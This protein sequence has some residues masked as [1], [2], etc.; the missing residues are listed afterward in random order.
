MDKKELGRQRRHKRIRKKIFGTPERPRLVIH[1]THKNLIAQLIDDING[2]VILGISTLN[3]ELRL[4]ADRLG[5]IKGAEIL[6]S[7]LAD[8]AKEKGVNKVVFDRG[9]YLYHGIVKIFAEAVRKGGIE[10]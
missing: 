8:K 3:K 10:F 1:R 4:R 9:G 6:G 5:N 2:K 7:V